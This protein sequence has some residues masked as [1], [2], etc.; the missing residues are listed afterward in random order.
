MCQSGL[1]N[2]QLKTKLASTPSQGKPHIQQNNAYQGWITLQEHTC[3]S[4]TV[5]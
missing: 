4:K 5:S 1:N 2:S 3:F